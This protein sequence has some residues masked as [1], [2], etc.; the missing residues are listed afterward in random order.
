MFA[1]SERFS[2]DFS[3]TGAVFVAGG[4]AM[5]RIRPILLFA[6][7]RRCYTVECRMQ[8]NSEAIRY[9]ESRKRR[10]MTD[11]IDRP[12]AY[13]LLSEDELAF[14]G[15][16]LRSVFPLPNDAPFDE[17]LTRLDKVAVAKERD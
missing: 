12:V 1:A 8:R 17:L 10:S 16:S 5:S 3:P 6:P 11:D 4:S 9:F 14:V 7:E 15:P 13:A 2:G